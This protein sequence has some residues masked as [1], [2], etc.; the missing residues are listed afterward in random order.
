MGP[1]TLRYCR[2]QEHHSIR[3]KVLGVLVQ[4]APNP[5][6]DIFSYDLLE[7]FLSLGH[8]LMAHRSGRQSG[9]TSSS[10]THK[11]LE[12]L[13]DIAMAVFPPG[14]FR[15][16]LITRFSIPSVEE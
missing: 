4:R 5:K 1:L 2:S 7:S 8:E 15:S 6:E 13:L 3:D 16:R 11:E 12:I 9:R 14:S 10:T